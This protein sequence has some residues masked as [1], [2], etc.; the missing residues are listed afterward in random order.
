MLWIHKPFPVYLTDPLK[1]SISIIY[2]FRTVV[3]LSVCIQ[4][5]YQLNDNLMGKHVWRHCCKSTICCKSVH[6]FLSD[7]SMKKKPGGGELV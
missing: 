1:H 3:S 4:L 6:M 7:K 5:F 2:M